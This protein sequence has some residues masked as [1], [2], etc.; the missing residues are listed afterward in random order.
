MPTPPSTQGPGTVVRLY[1]FALIAYPKSYRRR[2]A[3]EME[4]V[5][6]EQWRDVR[7]GGSTLEVLVFLLRTAGD[8]LLS[9]LS[10]RLST[11]SKHPTMKNSSSSLAPLAWSL[12]G[13]A[14]VAVVVLALVTS[15][16]LALPK[17]YM[18]SARVLLNVGEGAPQPADISAI[19]TELEVIQSSQVLRQA[20][21]RAHLAERWSP[22]YLGQ[23]TLHPAEIVEILRDKLE[24]HQFRNTR[25]AEIRVYDRDRQI[26]ADVA[27]A[28]AGSYAEFQVGSPEASRQR[29]MVVDAADLGLKP[30]R[31]N[32]RLNVFVGLV[33]GCLLGLGTAGALWRFLRKSSR[34]GQPSPSVAT[35][36]A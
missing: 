9:S 6:R 15:V 22:I 10:E 5:F 26:A 16:T 34:K 8:L 33:V 2:F 19:A 35:S 24:V 36:P 13:G 27:N 11:L 29:G 20:A 12:A 14:V 25:M 4:Q 30:I 7:S 23:G 32:V 28:I 17:I 21:L 3:P 1:R 18:S 31:P